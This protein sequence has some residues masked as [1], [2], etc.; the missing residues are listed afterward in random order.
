MAHRRRADADR[1]PDRVGWLVDTLSYTLRG[2]GR[3]SKPVAEPHLWLRERRKLDP[4]LITISRVVDELSLF[5][6]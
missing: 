4:H 1:K 5:S 2:C 3:P 6:T